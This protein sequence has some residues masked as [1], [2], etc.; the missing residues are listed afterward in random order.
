MRHAIPTTVRW[1]LLA[2][3]PI[4]C[5]GTVNNEQG[6][7]DGAAGSLTALPNS[8][9][10]AGSPDAGASGATGGGASGAAGG[11]ASGAAGGAAA[12]GGA[13]HGIP[14]CKSP[15]FDASSQ[16]VVCANGF[17]HRAQP[18]LCGPE[19]SAGSAGAPADDGQSS[20][21]AGGEILGG[22][23]SGTGLRWGTACSNDNDCVS[24]S[25]CVCNPAAYMVEK[26]F[27][28]PGKGVCVLAT[29]RTDADC[30][31]GSYCAVG[32][33][34]FSGEADPGFGCLRDDDECTVDADCDSS[35]GDIC[36]EE[37]RRTC[38]P[39]PE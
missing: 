1:I 20:A 39:P 15:T 13:S 2:A 24:G 23:D 37:E 30:G 27:I 36:F 33:L 26:P 31:A 3:V 29:C 4:A 19:S 22:L 7:G 21:G 9:G 18:S 17:A 35:A 34:N 10:E 5:S 6:T 8:A 11:G 16:L 12:G 14:I 32:N 38:S 28:R 25:A